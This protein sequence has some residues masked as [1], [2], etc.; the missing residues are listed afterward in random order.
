VTTMLEHVYVQ[1]SY[2]KFASILVAKGYRV[3]RV[4]QTETPEMLKE[5]ND[6]SRGKKD[7]VVARELCSVMSRGTR[8]YCHLDDLSLLESED[9]DRLSAS[10]LVCIKEALHAPPSTAMD[11]T[12]TD[13]TQVSADDALPEYGVCVVD[14]VLCTVTLA[15]FQDDRQR[16]RLRTL[17]ARYRPSEVLLEAGAHTAYTAGAVQLLAPRATVELL[18]PDAEM[19]AAKETVKL[20]HKSLYFG[21]GSKKSDESSA[22]AS[23]RG[24]PPV[25]KAVH[26]GLEDGTS[27]LVLSAFGGAVWQLRRSLIDYEVLSMG[28]VYGYI[29]PDEQTAPLGTQPLDGAVTQLST[30]CLF[31]QQD[32]ENHQITF[33]SAASAHVADNSGAMEVD[34][35][36][37]VSTADSADASDIKTMTLDEVALTNLEILVNNYDRT[38]KGSLWAFVNRTKS[39]F[40]RRL[41]RSWLCHPL[42]RCKDITRR[43]EA[44]A[45]LLGPLSEAA[46]DARSA[47]RGIPDLERL[48]TRVH[49]NGL[50][51]RDPVEHPDSRAILY[52]NVNVR[53][54]KDFADVLTGFETVIKV[55][56][57]FERCTVS[58]PLLRLALTSPAQGGKFPRAEIKQLLA[59][60]RE[61]FDEKQAKKEG[62]IRPRPGIDADFDAAKDDI[63][64]LEGELE[65]YLRDQKKALG[66]SDLKYFGT[67]KDRYQIEVPIALTNKVPREWTSKSQ[68]KTHR[69][70]W[71][72][73]IEEMLG[74]LTAAEDRLALAQKDTLRAVFEK[75]DA[76]FALWS[77]AISCMA[78]LDALL[79]VATVSSF[80]GYVRPVLQPLQQCEGGTPVLDIQGGRHPMLEFSMLQR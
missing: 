78:L 80:P 26:A 28:K 51:K 76:S 77:G 41:L 1:V 53:K 9:P 10:V 45:E 17:L 72:P 27:E 40:G 70:F 36:P 65:Q 23:L 71:T 48:L 44:V 69:R 12:Q 18:R 50:R 7:K 21:A 66:I 63:T 16:S 55:G 39:A 62:N 73:E 32:V 64:R 59:H 49:S 75:F 29:P 4:E 15:Q 2:G 47:L 57:L 58:S 24:W 3:A 35:S 42:Y 79:S 37:P 30:Q 34:G 13:A 11:A 61:I 19:L 22:E 6:A 31:T 25:L 54:I 8:T 20:I 33:D 67:N 5:R 43:Q 60:F 46:E 14:T 74:E 38:E 52:E 68:K 56:A